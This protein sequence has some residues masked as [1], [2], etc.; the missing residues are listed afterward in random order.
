M[1]AGFYPQ[2]RALLL[3]GGCRL[4]RQGC[5]S[6]EVWQTPSGKRLTVAV[7]IQSRFLA[8]DILKDAGIEK[9]L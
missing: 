4:V 2:L 6:H 5:G 7:T 1:G 3:A 8:N 9:R